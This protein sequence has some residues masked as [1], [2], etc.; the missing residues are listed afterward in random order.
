MSSP[1][2][3][4]SPTA[5][6]S[7]RDFIAGSA[8]LVGAAT[9][10]AALATPHQAR[11]AS[12]VPTT[13]DYEADIVI[14]GAGGAGYMA[15]CAAHEKGANAILLEKE[16]MTGGDSLICACFSS[17]PWPERVAIES[18]EEES[19]E[20]FVTDWL[21]SFWCSQMGLDGMDEPTEHPFIERESELYAEAMQWTS[22]VAGIEWTAFYER[23]WT[24]QPSWDHVHPRQFRAEAGIIPNLRE[25]VESYGDC[26]TLTNTRVYELIQNDAGRVIGVFA[27]DE[28]GRR[29]A[30]KAH[31]AVLVSTG[32][33]MGDRSMVG[34][35]LGLSNYPIAT[36][37]GVTG[38]GHKMVEQIGGALRCM[39]LGAHWNPRDLGT[40]NS[41]IVTSWLFYGG[42][43]GNVPGIGINAEGKRFVAESLG[44]HLFGKA[45]AEQKFGVVYY[46]VDAP[47]AEV[48]I[49][50][51]GGDTSSA[52]MYQADSLEGLATCMN[53]DPQTFVDEVGRY[54]G[55]V[56]AGTD[57]DFGKLMEGCTRIETAPYYAIA[58]QPKPYC[59]YGGIAVDL[60]AHVL[61]TEGAVI[62][63]L[64]AAGIC[65][66]SFAAQEGVFYMGG[67][68]QFLA[69]GRH[70]GQVMADEEPWE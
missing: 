58:I 4:T 6:T 18:G 16:P 25:L 21:D 62:P 59:S 60:D 64:Y 31:R 56:D 33:F 46:V 37:N 13:W 70:A 63:G 24:P 40:N 41:S 35:H 26:Q 28:A 9:A 45:G 23:S 44:Y 42:S 69:W 67:V 57:E 39:D 36:A 43:Q 1:T 61:D 2:N 66:G 29:I 68:R 48:L 11:A 55:F 3:P 27:I 10:G 49:Q 65:T 30:V 15:A 38:D 32:S 51:M 7:R 5:Q 52:I 54:N 14:V 8:A 19:V 22:D 12:V 17:G 47:A 34:N 20:K 53:V 50:C